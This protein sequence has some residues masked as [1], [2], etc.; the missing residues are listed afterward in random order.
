MIITGGVNVYPREVEDV[1][2]AHPAVQDAAVF[3]VPDDEFGE[4]VRAALNWLQTAKSR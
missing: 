1:L 4:S 2:I 3:G